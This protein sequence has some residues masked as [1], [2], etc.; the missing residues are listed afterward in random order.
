LTEDEKKKLVLYF[1]SGVYGSYN[2]WLKKQMTLMI[3]EKPG[4]F[5]K[6]RYICSR[7]FPREKSYKYYVNCK[8]EWIQII[9]GWS[10][11]LF[12]ALF[13]KKYR[14]RLIKEVKMLY[15]E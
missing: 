9:L 4:R 3:K 10:S 14:K 5:K 1:S 2:H 12:H 7:L 15:S 6:L 11:R 8:V 13:F